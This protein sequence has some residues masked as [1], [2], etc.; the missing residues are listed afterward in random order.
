MPGGV[1]L[2]IVMPAKSLFHNTQLTFVVIL[3]KETGH[4]IHLSLKVILNPSLCS[5][6]N[7]AKNLIITIC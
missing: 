7:S 5:R 4:N 3:K 6:I 1:T 2:K